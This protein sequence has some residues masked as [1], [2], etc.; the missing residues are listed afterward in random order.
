[1]EICKKKEVRKLAKEIGLNTAEKKD[2]Q[3]LCFIGKVKLP[4]F[5]QQ[6]LKPKTGKVVEIDSNNSMYHKEKYYQ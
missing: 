1:M 6:F 2:S 4:T 5:L 3:G